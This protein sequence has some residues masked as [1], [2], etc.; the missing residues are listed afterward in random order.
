MTFISPSSPVENYFVL[1]SG[2]TGTTYLTGLLR[3][4][5]AEIDCFQEPFPGWFFQIMSNLSAA[6]QLPLGLQ[7][8]AKSVFIAYRQHL[9]KKCVTSKLV[10]VNPFLY[11]LAPLISHASQPFH[12]IHM[13]RHPF[14]YICSMLNFKPGGLKNLFFH[15]RLWNP[16][17]AGVAGL[18]ATEWTHLHPVLQKAWLWLFINRQ[19]AGSQSLALS[20]HLLRF[21]DLC[22]SEPEKRSE[23]LTQIAVWLDLKNCRLDTIDP[24]GLSRNASRERNPHGAQLLSPYL[25]SA[26]RRICRPLMEQFG[27]Q[28]T[29]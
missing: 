28:D 18:T 15:S 5:A 6:G 12:L 8:F 29:E 11:G 22:H 19:I 21:E 20:Y 13:V 14:G 24:Q 2:R 10:E 23:T 26:I 9:K 1:S 7:H 25:K 16:T 3:S 4:A 27:Y 17:L